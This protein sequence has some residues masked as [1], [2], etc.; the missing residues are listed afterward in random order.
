M[1]THTTVITRRFYKCISIDSPKTNCPI[2]N[3]I[4]QRHINS[5]SHDFTRLIINHASLY[6]APSSPRNDILSIPFQTTVSQLIA[7][8]RKS[9]GIARKM[10]EGSPRRKRR[11]RRRRG[12]GRGQTSTAGSWRSWRRHS[13]PPTIPMCS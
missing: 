5:L 7:P 4:N 2:S 13:K 1:N 11:T 12:G 9:G 6:S 10:P 3:I 8:P